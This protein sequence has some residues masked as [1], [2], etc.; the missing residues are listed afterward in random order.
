VGQAGG[1]SR[2]AAC[3]QTQV[4]AL[5]FDHSLWVNTGG[6]SGTWKWV[7]TPGQATDIACDGVWLY[8]LNQDKTLWRANPQQFNGYTYVAKPGGAD[9]IGGGPGVL[10]ALNFDKSVWTSY[11]QDSESTDPSTAPFAGISWKNSGS[12]G[13]ASS[14]A[15]SIL[16]AANGCDPSSSS[17]WLYNW[18]SEVGPIPDAGRFYAV[19]EDHSLWYNDGLIAP[20]NPGNWIW[21]PTPAGVAL[22]QVTAFSST[23]LYAIDTTGTIWIV[24][25]AYTNQIS[26]TYNSLNLGNGVAVGISTPITF[27]AH[28]DGSYSFSGG[29]HNSGFV[30]CYLNVDFTLTSRDG[31]VLIYKLEGDTCGTSSLCGGGASRT[32]SWN[33]SGIDLEI[34]QL[35]GSLNTGW[36]PHLTVSASCGL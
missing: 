9:R 20:D 3:S 23:W 33:G 11:G 28:G 26:V 35:Y 1:A 2:I 27:T 5:N 21:F 8:V 10:T 22:N 17:C 31:Q 7:D 16:S 13:G 30:G 15:G 29:L 14:I 34:R 36:V 12:A 18:A 6:G 32:L 19:N 25:T 4:W 24:Q